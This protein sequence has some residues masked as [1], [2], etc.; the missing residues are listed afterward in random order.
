M[1]ALDERMRDIL[2][3]LHQVD[4]GVVAVRGQIAGLAERVERFRVVHRR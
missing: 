4:A 1:A 3:C 2:A